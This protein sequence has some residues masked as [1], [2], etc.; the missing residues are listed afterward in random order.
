MRVRGH[1]FH[2]C[3][4]YG[5]LFGSLACICMPAHVYAYG[6]G[7]HLDACSC[8]CFVSAAD[9]FLHARANVSIGS[10]IQRLLFLLTSWMSYQSAFRLTEFPAFICPP[11][12]VDTWSLH[13]VF[14]VHGMM[15]TF[16][17]LWRS[18]A[19]NLNTWRTCIS[20]AWI[21]N[22]DAACFTR[23]WTNVSFTFYTHTYSAN[24]VC[25]RAAAQTTYK[26]HLPCVCK[27]AH[28]CVRKQ[29]C[30]TFACH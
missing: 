27:F 29:I 4:G 20:R 13:R 8:I 1:I 30:C 23:L 25:S 24:H 12:V 19:Q 5:P 3:Y 18:T 28:L 9:I 22:I 16:R 14:A 7:R 10:P 15:C 17:I 2:I 11:I 6:C 21:R 26:Y